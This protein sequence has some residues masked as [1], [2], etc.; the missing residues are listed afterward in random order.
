[1][2]STGETEF[3][4]FA[5]EYQSVQHSRLDELNDL[6]RGHVKSTVLPTLIMAGQ[7]N[8]LPVL[9]RRPIEQASAEWT[10]Q[11]SGPIALTKD[12]ATLESILYVPL[13]LRQ[14]TE[15]QSSW[16]NYLGAGKAAQARKTLMDLNRTF[17][18]EWFQ[19]V[20]CSETNV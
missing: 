9:A 17:A 8:G 12:P 16:L 18:N 15:L 2:K 10:A 6:A 3:D 13:S 1:M 5:G 11:F 14:N 19:T 7:T 20:T 4:S